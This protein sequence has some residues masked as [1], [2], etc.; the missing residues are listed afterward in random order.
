MSTAISNSRTGRSRI[1]PR[2]SSS[3]ATY[4]D[5]Y[6]NRG[7]IESDDKNQQD[8]AIDDFTQAIK[9]DPS[10]TDA[11]SQ[12]CRGLCPPNTRR[13]PALADLNTAIGRQPG[14]ERAYLH[15]G[16]LYFNSGDTARALADLTKAVE[17]DPKDPQALYLRGAAKARSGDAT[18]GDADIAAAKTIDPDI[19]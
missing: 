5:P 6:F 18:G 10:I 4:A 14:L 8:K 16:T 17:L 7:T 13:A 15:R 3:T 12:P 19:N 11:Y 1:S 9:L 2:R